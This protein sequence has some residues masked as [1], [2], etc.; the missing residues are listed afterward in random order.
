MWV[1]VEDFQGLWVML[2]YGFFVIDKM[3]IVGGKELED[4]VWDNYCFFGL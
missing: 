3:G 1:R 4:F 2:F